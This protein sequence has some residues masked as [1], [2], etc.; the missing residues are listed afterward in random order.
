[1]Q[2]W[3]DM[4]IHING[5]KN[6]LGYEYYYNYK[7]VTGDKSMAKKVIDRVARGSKPDVILYLTNKMSEQL[8]SPNDLTNY[9]HF[10]LS[11]KQSFDN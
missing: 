4:E 10:N 11:L 3:D 1:M 7:G 2:D 5:Q 6:G 8:T 9:W